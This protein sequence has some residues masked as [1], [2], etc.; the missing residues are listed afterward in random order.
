MGFTLKHLRPRGML[1]LSYPVVPVR[2]LLTVWI[3]FVDNK[4]MRC[5][6]SLNFRMFSRIRSN[7]RRIVL[8][9]RVS[10]FHNTAQVVH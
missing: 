4:S 3:R 5:P 1:G 8:T 10:S 2:K 7:F 6:E 9:L